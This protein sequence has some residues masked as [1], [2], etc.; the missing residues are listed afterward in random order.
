[1][2]KLTALKVKAAKAPGR[3]MDG[4]GLMYVVKP[5]GASSWVLRKQVNGKRRDFGLGSGQDVTLAEARG[6]AVEYGKQ[7][8]AGTD[9]VLEKHAVQK[10]AA[11]MPTFS[12]AAK[13][14]HDEFK[15][16]WRNAK[17]ADQWLSTLEA[18]AFP[19]IGK[20]P[21]DRVDAGAI[22]SVLSPIWLKTPETG[23]RVKQR[24]GAVLDW[25]FAK[26]FRL[27]EAPTRAIGKG[28]KQQ[29]KTD[30]HFAALDYAAVPALMTALCAKKTTGRAALLFLIFTAARSGEVR[31]ATWGEMDLEAALWTIP[32]TRMKA[33]KTHVVPLSGGALSILLEMKGERTVKAGEIVF[34]G[35]LGKPLSDMTLSKALKAE[36]DA[37]ATVHGFR[38]SFRDW[39]AERTSVPGEIV[40][41]ALA[42]T[43]T[44]RVEAAYRR[45]NYLDHRRCLMKDWDA[46]VMPSPVAAADAVNIEIT[47]VGPDQ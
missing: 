31:G 43:N 41:A 46:Y 11:G 36:T 4:D 15:G 1:M 3:Y 28:L 2:G 25:A 20:L 34:P 5:S 16:G 39:A 44:N 47:E 22:I 19:I 17:H 40:E 8:R 27:N 45:T 13:R 24:I 26:G 29:P 37:P 23:R 18:H 7:L 9:P 30:G 12:E 10:R 35:N 33:G 6:I 21:V 38:S 42:H 32:G 14:A